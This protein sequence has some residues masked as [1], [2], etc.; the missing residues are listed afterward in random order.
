MA[1]KSRLDASRLNGPRAV[2][3]TLTICFSLSA[4]FMLCIVNIPTIRLP[5]PLQANRS[6]FPCRPYV[7][8]LFHVGTSLV[9]AWHIIGI[10]KDRGWGRPR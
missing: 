4:I 5:L 1:G 2:A 9:F 7:T 6:R 8:R 10:V 3:P